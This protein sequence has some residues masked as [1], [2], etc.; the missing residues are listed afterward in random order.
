MLSQSQWLLNGEGCSESPFS[1]VPGWYP[2]RSLLGSGGKGAVVRG[3]CRGIIIKLKSTW[4]IIVICGIIIALSSN[5]DLF[6]NLL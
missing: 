6:E 3:V 5:Y 4:Q 2:S 1:V